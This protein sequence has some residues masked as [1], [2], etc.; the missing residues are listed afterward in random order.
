MKEIIKGPV[1]VKFAGRTYKVD[2]DVV[3]EISVPPGN[4]FASAEPIADFDDATRRG[5]RLDLL[6]G[7]YYF[8]KVQTSAEL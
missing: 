4:V 7:F 5:W 6:T 8:P 2:R 3:I 1:T